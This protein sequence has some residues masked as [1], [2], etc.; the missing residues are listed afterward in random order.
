MPTFAALI[1]QVCY[2]EEVRH[3]WTWGS[4]LMSSREELLLLK[5]GFHNSSPSHSLT[6]KG[7]YLYPKLIKDES[8]FLCWL[9]S[10]P[11]SSKVFSS[12]WEATGGG[13]GTDQCALLSWSVQ[14]CLALC[15]CGCPPGWALLYLLMLLRSSS[16]HIPYS[17]KLSREKNFHKFRGFVAICESSLR[18]IW[19]RGVL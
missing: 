14:W 13:R 8:I 6:R 7:S 15:L 5:R 4:L 3:A 18:K 12:I 10:F 1:T 11:T 9:P 19:G 16:L 17:G 2:R